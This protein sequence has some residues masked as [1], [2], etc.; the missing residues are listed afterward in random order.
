[1]KLMFMDLV[2]G[3]CSKFRFKVEINIHIKGNVLKLQLNGK[4]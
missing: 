2:F 3:Y 4:F 1:L